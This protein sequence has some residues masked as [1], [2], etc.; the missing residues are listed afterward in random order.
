MT[1]AVFPQGSDNVYVDAVVEMRRVDAF[2]CQFENRASSAR[3]HLGL[4]AVAALFLGGLGV[5]GRDVPV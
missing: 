2:G 4:R 5:P 3:S 1:P